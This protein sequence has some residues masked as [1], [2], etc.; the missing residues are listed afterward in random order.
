MGDL[1]EADRTGYLQ[2]TPICPGGGTYTINE[3]DD[4][5]TCTLE[6]DADAPHVLP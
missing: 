3:V 2:K 5:P 1:V 6:T 4:D